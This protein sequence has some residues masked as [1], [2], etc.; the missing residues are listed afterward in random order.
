MAPTKQT[1]SSEKC[2]EALH[3]LIKNHDR[4]VRKKKRGQ[5]VVDIFKEFGSEMKFQ[6][7]LQDMLKNLGRSYTE[8][9]KQLGYSGK[10]YV[11]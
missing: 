7:S 2:E 6:G 3:F 9:K 10:K 5:K 4:Y 1:H 8:I 11:F